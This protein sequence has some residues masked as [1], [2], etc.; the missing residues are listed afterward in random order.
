MIIEATVP[1]LLTD[2]TDGRARVKL[3]ADTL[4]GAIDRLF[5][6]YPLLKRHVY[7]E[8]GSVRKH[9][10]LCYND[11]N[12]AWLDRLDVPLRDGDKLHVMQLVSGG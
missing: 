6:D 10:M 9:V 1:G 2:C 7:T 5:A 11:Q 12:I 8:S 3:E 4:Q